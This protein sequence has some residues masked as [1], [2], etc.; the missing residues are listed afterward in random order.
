MGY[1]CVTDVGSRPSHPHTAWKK[2]CKIEGDRSV[3]EG[4]LGKAS[5]RMTWKTKAHWNGDWNGDELNL[6]YLSETY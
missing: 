1:G 6:S 3:R 5:K 2:S 4:H